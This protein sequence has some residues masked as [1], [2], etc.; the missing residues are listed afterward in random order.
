[1]YQPSYLDSMPRSARSWAPPSPHPAAGEVDVHAALGVDAQFVLMLDAYRPH[2]GLA[3]LREL[4]TSLLLRVDEPPEMLH[5]WVRNEQVFAFEWAGEAWM[6]LFQLASATMLPRE[7]VRAIA[8]ELRATHD[9]F[10][11]AAW[12]TRPHACLGG[13]SPLIRLAQDDLGVVLA[14]R[15]S[16]RARSPMR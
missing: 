16:A 5:A 6:P 15:R 11:I 7:D 3:R 4:E 12:F 2:G 10:A 8:S 14:A 1:M 13:A 9:P